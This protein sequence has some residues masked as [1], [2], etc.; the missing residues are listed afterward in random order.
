MTTTEEPCSC[1][2]R[3]PDDDSPFEHHPF[4]IV[5]HREAKTNTNNNNK[6][7]PMATTDPAFPFWLIRVNE[8][9]I[10][11][12]C[13]YETLTD[14]ATGWRFTTR[15]NPVLHDHLW[16][17]NPFTGYTWLVDDGG[18]VHPTPQKVSYQ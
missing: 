1:D 6:E 10:R 13:R 2:N 18:D 9:T 12:I 17:L 7:L 8:Y 16:I 14:A 15:D 5:G 3:H 11:T 4:C